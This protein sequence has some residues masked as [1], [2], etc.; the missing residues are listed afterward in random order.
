MAYVICVLKICGVCLIACYY[1]YK[2]L[3][4]YNFA[5]IKIYPSSEVQL[6]RQETQFRGTQARVLEESLWKTMSFESRLFWVWQGGHFARECLIKKEEVVVMPTTKKQKPKTHGRVYALTQQDAMLPTT[7]WQVRSLYVLIMLDPHTLISLQVAFKLT[8]TLDC[9]LF[10]V[11]HAWVC[12]L[13]TD[14]FL[15]SAYI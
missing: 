14:K 7:Q 13:T 2:C 3:L 1:S 4:L 11:A 10:V 12:L 9:E 5:F 15:G 8:E 6:R